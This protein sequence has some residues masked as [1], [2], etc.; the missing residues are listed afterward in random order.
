[1]RALVA[2]AIADQNADNASKFL[3]NTLGETCL[4]AAR[5]IPEIADRIV[6][7]DRAIRWGFGWELGPFEIWDA[8]GVERMARALE[9][10]GKALPP[11]ITSLLSSGQK[12]FYQVEN[13]HPTYFDP[14]AKSPAPVT[15]PEGVIFLTAAQDQTKVVQKNS[16]ARLIDIGDGVLCCES[17]SKMNA[18]GGDIVAMI[19][20]GLKRLDEDFEAM[21][22]ANDAVNFSVGANLM[23][24]LVSAQEQ[25]W[26]DVHLAVRQFQRVNMAI[27]YASRPV[28]VAPQGLALGGGCEITL[29][30]PHVQAAAECYLGLVETGVGLIPA[31]GGCKEMLIRANEHAA[32]G[33]QQLAASAEANMDLFHALKPIF[34]NMAMAKVSTSAEDARLLGYLRRDDRVSMNRDR[35]LGDAKAAALEMAREGYRPPA[36]VEIR[37]LGEQ[38]LAG[39][40]L[41]IHMLL[42]GEFITEY[43]AVVARKL[44]TIVSGGALSAPQNVSEQYLLDLERE[45]FVSLCGERKTQER[46][47]HTLKTGKPLRN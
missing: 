19:H 41:L 32:G 34:E 11:L 43:D 3:W 10:Q 23:L 30:A 18:I 22:I 4:Y 42:R 39:A 46:I 47:A 33:A 24:L 44:A 26:D 16:G 20:A 5:R 38:F 9:T 31:G 15:Q 13:G 28:V 37:V 27:K 35:L 29:H 12:S 40:K 8:L 7:V 36:P 6:D 25:E 17:R 45:A 14:T 21:V 2:P 1:L